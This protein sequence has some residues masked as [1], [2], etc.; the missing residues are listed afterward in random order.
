M[1]NFRKLKQD[2]SSSILKEGKEFFDND[3]VIKAKVL[4][5]TSDTLRIS[6]TVTGNYENNYECT[7]EIDR[8]ESEVIDSDCDCPS[9][10]D[11]AHLA[12]MTFYLEKHLD[13]I[14]VDFSKETDL[15]QEYEDLDKEKKEEL[16]SAVRQAE[17]QHKKK[18]GETFRKEL[19]EEYV[20][21]AETFARCP[22]FLPMETL[23]EDRAEMAVILTPAEEGLKKVDPLQIQLALRLPQRNKPLIV[24]NVKDFINGVRYHESIFLGGKRYFFTL[25][26]FDANS[27]SILKLLMDFLHF[28]PKKTERNQKLAEIETESFGMIL[29]R[30]YELALSTKTGQRMSNNLPC[31]FIGSVEKPLKF[32]QEP[33]GLKFELEYLDTPASKIMIDPAIELPDGQFLS[34]HSAFVFE[35]AKPGILHEETFYQFESKIK[36]AHLRNL[37][38]VRS[39]I[40][41]QPLF[42]SLIENALPELGR[43][44][45]IGNQKILDKFVTLPFVEPIKAKCRIEYLDGELEAYLTF[46]YDGLEIPSSGTKLTVEQVTKFV[47]EEGVLARNLVEEQKLIDELFQEFIFYPETGAYVAKSE[48]KIVEFMT[49][50]LPQ[51]RDRVHFD[52]PSNLL[53]QFIYDQTCF[54][55]HLKESPIIDCYEVQL[56]VK[57]DLAGVKIDLLWDCLSSK[58]NYIELEKQKKKQGKSKTGS[59]SKFLVLDLKELGHVVQILDELGVACLEDQE[60]ERPLWSLASIKASNF[61]GFPF[62]FSMSTKL[63]AIQKQLLGEVVPKPTA[64]PKEV[65]ADLRKYQLEGVHWLERLRTM[66]L[67]GILADDMGLGKTLQT[68]IALSQDRKENSKSLSLVVCPTS[69][70]Y[71]WK[72]E[73]SKFN[74][75]TK[76]LIVDGAPSQ[77]KKTLKEAEKNHVLVTS[78][79]L[80]QKDIDLYKDFNFSYVVLDEG[81]HIKNRTTRN[82]KSV[83]Q[84][85][86]R[87]KL[88]LTGTPIENSLEELWSLFDFLMPGLLNTYERFVDKYVKQTTQE[89]SEN[90]LVNLRGKVSPFILR[91]M[92]EDV[93]EDLPPVSEMVYHCHLSSQQIELYRSYAMS[94]KEELSKLVKK[95][96]FEKVQIHVLATLTRLKQ[97]CCH[98]ALFAKEKAEEGDS[99]KYD[100][101]LE[102]L[103]TL[104]E[105]KHK[106]VIFS[107][108]TKMLGLMKKDLKKMGITFSYLDGSTKNRLDVVKEFNED[109]NISVFLVSLKAGGTGLNLVGADTVIHYDQWYNPAVRDQALDRVHRIGQDKP[110]S[111]ITLVTLG[112]IEEKI[113]ELQNKKRGLVKQVVN[114]DEEAIARLTWEDVLELLET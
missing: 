40:V 3:N 13:R 26:S 101:M 76:V 91:R 112:T 78:Y 49:G 103:N 18:V 54:D 79:S 52:C 63:K 73:F 32:S 22:F 9:D 27:A 28:E 75:D 43:F 104:V 108:Y 70:V 62:T 38:T 20:S 92:K 100:L 31:L 97:I 84:L 90:P 51:Y 65:R 114:C 6:G 56:K 19:M 2:F 24:S 10:F 89:T 74:S 44:G 59:K 82:A 98:P 16:I 83:K 88:V 107:Q 7:L 33:V 14:I 34:P 53:D 17:T 109:P 47:R 86:A 66:H 94:A 4:E 67:N 46:D 99:A 69:L 96:G 37:A 81:Q 39:L 21:A 93:L 29:A 25:A 41:P 110:V 45:K 58:R 80:M 95:E 15:E 60:I 12:A 50:I 85:Q 102:L 42:G 105:G 87:H 5:L 11:C 72:E 55:V 77:R 68:I 61:E 106:T 1:L 30:S 71:N 113:I 48:K 64:V 36:R 35:C 57:G 111:S 23:I 8:M